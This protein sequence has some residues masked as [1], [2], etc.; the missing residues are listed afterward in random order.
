MRFTDN[1][2]PP[3]TAFQYGTLQIFSV[4]VA[5]ISGGL[6]WPLHVFGV[7][8]MR[9]AVDRRCNIIFNRKRDSFQTLT[10]EVSTIF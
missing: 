10:Q 1:P 4:K 6:Q 9:D 5:G 3:Y 8:A 2:A 7:V